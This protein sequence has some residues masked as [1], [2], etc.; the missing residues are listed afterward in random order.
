MLEDR[1]AYWSAYKEVTTL[2]VEP[3]HTPQLNVATEFEPLNWRCCYCHEPFP[4]LARMMDHYK[5]RN[6]SADLTLIPRSRHGYTA[7]SW[8]RSQERF[9]QPSIRTISKD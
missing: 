9:N 4:S 2:P 6:L 1:S 3:F 5:E 8:A 7:E